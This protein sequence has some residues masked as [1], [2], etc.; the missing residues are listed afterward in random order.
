MKDLSKT[1]WGERIIAAK[2]RGSFTPQD[3]KDSNSWATC[4]CGGLDAR[5]I[6]RLGRPDDDTLFDLGVRFNSC[7]L[8]NLTDLAM[9]TLLHIEVRAAKVLAE[10]AIP[11]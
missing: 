5:L 9:V 10:L 4:A 3:L 2:E 6:D 11:N 1:H 7:I 8:N